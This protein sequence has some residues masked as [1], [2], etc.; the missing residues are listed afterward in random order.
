MH[1]LRLERLSTKSVGA[2]VLVETKTVT[3]VVWS[4]FAVALVM[5][6]GDTD[7]GSYASNFLSM[8]S[9]DIISAVW[10]SFWIGAGTSALSTWAQVVGQERVGPSRAAVCYASQPLF[11]AGLACA[12]GIDRLTP[13]EVVGGALIVAA[14]ALL[15]IG[16]RRDKRRGSDEASSP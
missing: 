11:A 10:W 9:G 14:G 2:T 1:V 16:D 3:Q 12:F 6:K 8:P 5:W 4:A 7:V 15:A 13:Q